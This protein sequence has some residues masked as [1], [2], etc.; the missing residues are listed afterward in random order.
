MLAEERDELDRILKGALSAYPA[1]PLLGLEARILR[2]LRNEGRAAQPTSLAS[3]LWGRAVVVGL[4]MALAAVGVFLSRSSIVEKPA[5]SNER[6]V[7]RQA[8][9]VKGAVEAAPPAE[10]TQEK[11]EIVG[12]IR[13]TVQ[14]SALRKLDV[15]P[16]PSPLTPEELALMRM[17]KAVPSELP[18][19]QERAGTVEVEPIQIQALGIKPLLIDGD[20]EGDK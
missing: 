12:T 15:F 9:S 3:S 10:V 8:S 19:R 4:S 18:T 20:E 14:R 17:T 5:R 7:E 6:I 16:T 13:G 1:E 2:R 11:R